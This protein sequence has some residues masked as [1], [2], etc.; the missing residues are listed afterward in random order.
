MSEE[1]DA[2]PSFAAIDAAITVKGGPFE[3]ETMDL[4]HG[5]VRVWK[6]APASFREFLEDR[7]NRYSD[8]VIINEP[9]PEPAEYDDRRDVT[10]GELLAHAYKLAAWLREQ[11]IRSG[12]RVAVGGQ[13]SSGWITS[14][15]AAHFLGAVP[16]CLNSTV[17][18]EVQIHCLILTRPKIVLVDAAGAEVLAPVAEHLADNRVGPLWC[19]NSTKHLTQRAQAYVEDLSNISPLPASV[20]AVK[21]K[22]GF[23][24][25]PESDALVLFTSGTTSLPKGVLITQRQG[26]QHVLTASVP[27]LRAAMRMGV[28]FEMALPAV[29]EPPAEGPAVLMPVPLFH[30]TG[31]LAVMI[32]M[33]VAGAKMIFMRRWSVPD[34]VKLMVNHNIRLISGVPSITTAIL[35]SGLLPDDYEM[36]GM[37]YGGAAP[38]KRLPADVKARFPAA[39]VSHGWGMTECSGL[40]IAIGGQDYVDRPE[41]VG[42]AI[43]IGDMRIVDMETGKPVPAGTLGILHVR[44]GC[45]MK[46]YL[47]NDK[48][49]RESFTADGWFDTGDV[50]YINEEGIL[51]LRDRAKDMIIRGGENIASAEVENAVA[52]D[53]RI[54]E[55]AAVAV[56]DPVLGERVGL[57]VSLA[58]R[59][60]ATP[61][62]IIAEA[63]K[64][65]R[66]PARP[67]VCVIFPDGL[68]INANGKVLKNEVKDIV[69]EQWKRQGG[70]QAGAPKA[71]L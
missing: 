23:D 6:H 43:P 17:T 30:V 53:S 57:G 66:Y 39:F 68:P 45:V 3:M 34:A 29:H 24:V 54:A 47:Y 63:D 21:S 4:G 61:E 14:F 55:V 51:Y 5:P 26:M 67:V 35:Q 69:G 50:G 7:L 60:T 48:A 2:Q 64:R 36:D 58:P 20:E 28:P 56:P 62:S 15:V 25:A 18:Q 10:Y 8:R 49:N 65:L 38:P 70:K 9:V 46:E 11:G 27:A 37:S 22:K 16:V 32:R 1:G 40:F 12:D 59:A 19:W 71:R 41:A 42:V 52:Q 44:G 31:L 33:F 13:N